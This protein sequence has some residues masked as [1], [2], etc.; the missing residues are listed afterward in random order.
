MRA[1]TIVSSAC[2]ASPT[3]GLCRDGRM[4]GHVEVRARVAKVER[5]AKLRER[6]ARRMEARSVKE[7]GWKT[8][9]LYIKASVSERKEWYNILTSRYLQF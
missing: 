1:K 8:Y 4:L 2:S 6:D 9:W 3:M 5:D 7:G